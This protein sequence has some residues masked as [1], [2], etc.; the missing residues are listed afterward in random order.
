MT[1]LIYVFMIMAILMG[2]ICMFVIARDVIEDGKERREKRNAKNVV[3]EKKPEEKPQEKLNV[4]NEEV[5]VTNNAVVEEKITTPKEEV[6]T[7][8]IEDLSQTI[9]TDNS[10]VVFSAVTQTLD[11]KYLELSS[12]YKGY[13]DEIVKCAMSV[14]GSK[15]I[16]NANYEEYKVGLSSLVKL[17]IKR[18]IIICELVISNLTFKAYVNDNKV[19]MKQ[20][21]AIIKVV[22]DAS[23]EAVKD[24]IGIAVKAI[25]EEKEYKKEQAKLR[26][27][28]KQRSR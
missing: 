28:E 7:T 16:K 15:R 24:S 6:A 12:A 20:A 5:A 26:R 2:M 3:I 10:A 13:Y 4:A 27:K 21:P 18:G 22:D 23:C 8:T 9:A 14:E 19:A 25:Q 1:E 11:E 17:K